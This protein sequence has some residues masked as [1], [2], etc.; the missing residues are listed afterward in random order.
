MQVK[1]KRKI[2]N[3]AETQLQKH[4]IVWRTN[5]SRLMHICMRQKR[6][7]KM[8]IYNADIDIILNFK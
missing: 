2:R 4:Y 3:G 6:M 1:K 7:N 5:D 8:Q